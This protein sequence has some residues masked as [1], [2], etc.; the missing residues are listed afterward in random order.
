MMTTT[1][2]A[3]LPL[4]SFLCPF[5]LRLSLSLAQVHT[6]TPTLWIE[7][8]RTRLLRA[9]VPRFMFRIKAMGMYQPTK[10]KIK[11][12]TNHMDTTPLLVS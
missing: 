8:S 6:P 1:H 11:T 7:P 12:K 3:H 9:E 5:S 10:T 4:R 2:F